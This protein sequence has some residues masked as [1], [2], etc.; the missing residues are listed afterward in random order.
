MFNWLKKKSNNSQPAIRDTFFGDLP[1]SSWTGNN[2]T[3]EPWTGFQ[4]VEKHLDLGETQLAIK[5]LEN[6]TQTAHLEAR[7][8]VQA[9]HFLKQLGVMPPADKAKEVCGVV[10]EVSMKEGFD[11]V[12]AYADHSARYFNYSGAL[13]IWENPDDSLQAEI[14]DLLNASEKIIHQIGPWEADRPGVPPKGQARI[15]IL[16]PSGLHFGQAPFDAL[17][18]DEMGGP[19]IKAA[20]TLIQALIKKSEKASA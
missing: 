17:A 10:V 11:I 7:H 1:I 19:I 12:A 2:S 5:E 20:T 15:S 6:I 9:W 18:N 8:Y 3:A 16:T 14:D 13:V 4:S